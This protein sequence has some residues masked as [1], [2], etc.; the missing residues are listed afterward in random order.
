MSVLSADIQHSA[1]RLNSRG[2]KKKREKSTSGKKEPAYS[3]LQ[4]GSSYTWKT[5]ISDKYPQQSRTQNQHT[6]PVVNMQRKIPGRGDPFTKFKT[7]KLKPKNKPNRGGK[8]PDLYNENFETLKKIL[9]DEI[10]H[11]H[12]REENVDVLLKAVH[13]FKATPI[14]VPSYFTE[15]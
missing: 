8:R 3:Y 9:E 11:V 10:S 13:R 15:I 1:Q 12:R 2:M 14:K 7:K 4:T 5:L 6:K